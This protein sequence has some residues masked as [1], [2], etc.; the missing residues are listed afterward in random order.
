MR[1]EDFGF[2]K[3]L[4]AAI[5]ESGFRE[6]SPIQEKAIPLV[7]DGHDLIAQ[8]HTGTGKTAA[9]ALPILH[10]LAQKSGS[11][12][13]VIVPTREL[14]TQVSD[15]IY[16]FG[17]S[18][19]MKTA[20]VYGG[21]PYARQIKQIAEASAIVATPGRLIDLLKNGKISINPEFIVLDE[22]DEMLDMGFLDDIYEIFSYLPKERQTLLFSATMSREI[23]TLAHKILKEPETVS[24]SGGNITN[25][26][27]KQIYY[28]V[29]EHERDDALIRLLDYK[30]PSKSIIFCRMKKEVD[31][32]K[33]MLGARGFDAKG[34]H[35]DMDQKRREEV[36]RSFKRGAC[37]ILVATDVAARGLDV[38]DVSHVFNYHIPFDSESYVHRIGRTG[39]AGREGTAVS[40]VTPH[41]FK[42]L[43]R[44]QKS[45]GSEMESRIVPRM[46]DM[47]TMRDDALHDRIESQEIE[48]EA[49]TAI[50]ILKERYDLTTIACKLLSMLRKDE[51][52][53]GRDKIGKNA[54]EIL[55]LIRSETERN[56][57]RRHKNNRSGESK[58]RRNPR[59]RSR[60]AH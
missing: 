16:R 26:N 31:R 29:D 28:V 49:Y 27:I 50:E 21:S 18:L 56:G 2:T 1:F 22:A 40:I 45:I 37:D 17:K 41:E 54:E 42:T 38:N 9:F 53:E 32:L 7:M 19:N 33:D 48:P 23:E 6:P 35:G 10:R 14:A 30:N 39:R 34:L 8:A 60:A 15:E 3:K 57:S 13:L 55:R 46:E 12:A 58:H 52:L 44:I 20:A 47:R 36:M 5:K 51:K 43:R 4:H 24:I 11:Q 59:R 25:T